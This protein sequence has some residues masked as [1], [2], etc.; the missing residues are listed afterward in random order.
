VLTQ[1]WIYAF[2]LILPAIAFLAI[3]YWPGMA[4]L[5]SPDWGRKQIGIVAI[6][7]MAA[8]T[9]VL[10]WW[11]IIWFEGYVQS[12]TGGVMGGMGGL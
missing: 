3:K 4:Y 5:K 1:V 11:G 10:T 6:I 9:I 12:A 7:L 8:S 2:S